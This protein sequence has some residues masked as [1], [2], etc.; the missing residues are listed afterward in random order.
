MSIPLPDVNKETC[1]GMFIMT[2]FIVVS[3][4]SEERGLVSKMKNTKEHYISV[5]VSASELHISPGIN[6]TNMMLVEERQLQKHLYILCIIKY[7]ENKGQ[8]D[9]TPNSGSNFIS[10]RE[11]NGNC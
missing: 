6:F 7:G 2:A 11:N 5:K 8:N 9:I 3:L 10:E 1:I 4:W